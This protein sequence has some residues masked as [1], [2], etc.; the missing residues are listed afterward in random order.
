M[1]EVGEC[2][3]FLFRQKMKVT[4]TTQIETLCN[5]LPGDWKKYPWIPVPMV[6]ACTVGWLMLQGAGG[7]DDDT[8][9][10]NN[11]KEQKIHVLDLQE[12]GY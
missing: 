10:A 4:I 7:T 8:Y 5:S 2:V 1:P 12:I 9:L 3:N 6:P 11:S